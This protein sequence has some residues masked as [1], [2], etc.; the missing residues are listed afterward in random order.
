M[1]DSPKKY[2][3]HLR[4]DKYLWVVRLAK[5]R[6]LATALISKN[7]VLCNDLPVKPSKEI[8]AGDILK[9]QK[10]NAWFSFNV[11]ALTDRRIGAPSV[12]NY[13][14]DITPEEE[15]NKWFKYLEAQKAYQQYGTGKPT[16]KDRRDLFQFKEGDVYFDSEE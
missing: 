2:D 8:K 4:I 15:R 6:S 7:K 16:K 1:Q 9:I 10:S 13:L 3:K 12:A 5:T 14:Q 11:I